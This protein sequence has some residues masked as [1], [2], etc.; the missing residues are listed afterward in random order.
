VFFESLRQ[1][2]FG[3]AVNVDL[4]ST[5][6]KRYGRQQGRCAGPIRASMDGPRIIR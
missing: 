1:V 5:V 2:G 3:E 4:D 6:F